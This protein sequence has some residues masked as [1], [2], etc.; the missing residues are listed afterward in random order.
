M[1]ILIVE[2]DRLVALS[3]QFIL[4]SGGC[5][6]IAIVGDRGAALAAAERGR[7]DLALVDLNLGLEASGLDVAAALRARGVPCLFTTGTPP[8][9]PRPDLALGCIRKPYGYAT[10]F[11]ALAAAQAALRGEP[12]GPAVRGFELYRSAA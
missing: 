1:R 4:E 11:A 8:S 9:E 12:A 2:D 7:P 6:A 5:E 10:L 3:L